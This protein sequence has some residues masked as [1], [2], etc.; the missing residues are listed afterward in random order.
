MGLITA[1]PTMKVTDMNNFASKIVGQ[2]VTGARI[3][4]CFT[5][6]ED[7]DGWE[8]CMFKLFNVLNGIEAPMFTTKC[9]VRNS[10][11]TLYDLNIDVFC[12]CSDHIANSGE[13]R[14]I[15]SVVMMIGDNSVEMQQIL[16]VEKT[17]RKLIETLKQ[18]LSL[19]IVEELS[20]SSDGVTHLCQTLTIGEIGVGTKKEFDYTTSETH[21][22]FVQV[23]ME[24][25]R[26]RGDF[27]LLMRA[28]TFGHQ[29]S[30]RL[31]I[32]NC[33]PFF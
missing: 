27:P 21:R 20:G 7:S 26:I 5:D 33:I 3:N 22:F 32:N 6:A 8:Q 31:K 4:E 1:D 30:H 12:I 18:V 19:N 24:F 17:N 11:G 14:S 25:D 29:Y 10:S 2:E 23:F 9:S 16:K 28:R 13:H 15:T